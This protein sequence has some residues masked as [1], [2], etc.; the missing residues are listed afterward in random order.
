MAR[1]A[2]AVLLDGFADFFLVQNQWIITKVQ[3]FVLIY[4]QGHINRYRFLR[5]TLNYKVFVV[6][7]GTLFNC[8]ASK[9]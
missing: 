9:L 3:I 1:F 5:L 6:C 8:I 2:G 4:D 7:N